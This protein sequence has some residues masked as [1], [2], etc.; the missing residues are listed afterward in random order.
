MNSDSIEEASILQTLMVHNN[1]KQNYFWKLEN[2]YDYIRIISKFEY[3]NLDFFMNEIYKN[4]LND[5][6]YGSK[7]N[8]ITDT[9]F[10]KKLI[11]QIITEK[12][13]IFFFPS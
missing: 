13:F 9:L 2:L 1:F 7:M 3:K 11:N 12:V 4:I 8:N 6:I 10:G 5:M